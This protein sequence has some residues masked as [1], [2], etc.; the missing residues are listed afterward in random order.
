MTNPFKEM[1]KREWIL[2]VSSMIIVAVSN[3]LTG[4]V[5][6]IT[7]LATLTGM[8]ALIFIARGDVWGQVLTVAFSLMYAAASLEFRY[9]GEMITYLGMTAPIA[10]FSIVSWLRNPYETGKNEVKIH[11]LSQKQKLLL[12]FLTVLVTIVFYFILRALDT[13][14]LVFS[15]IS[16]TTSFLASSLMLCRSSFYALAYGAND[17]VLIVLWSL[18]AAENIKYLPMIVCFF[19]FL[20][21]DIYGYISWKMREKKQAKAQLRK[22]ILQQ[23]A[24]LSAQE[25]KIRSEKIC[26][27]VRE[28]CCYKDAEAVCLYMPIRNEVDVTFLAEPA[29]EEG[30]TVWLPKVRDGRMD[31]YFYGPETSLEE[32]SYHIPEPK[33]ERI[34]VPDQHT[35]IIMPGAVF[36]REGDRIGY[37]GGYYDRYL[38]KFSFCHTVAVC[39]DFQI[40]PDIPSE[41]HDIRPETILWG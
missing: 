27:A 20:V 40:V 31:F 9:Y 30:K 2:W 7:L 5:H 1:K 33:S 37:G 15:T 23:R 24:A 26:K 3:V 28:E 21:N 39:Y 32:G 16:I 38:E 36:S 8:T 6:G 12:G 13:P 35:L 17:M 29:W 18:A 41:S 4:D 14:N 25:V 22:K 19:M 34:L 10:V 11:K